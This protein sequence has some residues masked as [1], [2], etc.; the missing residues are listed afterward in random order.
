MIGLQQVPK[1]SEPSIYTGAFSYLKSSILGFLTAVFAFASGFL[2]NNAAFQQLQI[3]GKTTAG[4]SVAI[5]LFLIFLTLE[6]IFINRRSF[7]ASMLVAS[8]VALALG[9]FANFSQNLLLAL[10]AAAVIIVAGGMITRTAL[11]ESLK[12]SF[13]RVAN[14]S[15]KFGILALAV[16]AAVLFFNVF[17]TKP[18]EKNN[19][20]LSEGLMDTT[21]QI[22]SKPLASVFGGVDFSKTLRDS[23]T[24]MVDQQ[25]QQDPT[26][27]DKVTLAQRQQ[28]IDR[29]LHDLQSRLGGIFGGT[30]NVDEKLSSAL[31]DAFLNKINTLPSSARSVIMII[32]AVLVLFTVLAVSPIIRPIIAGLAFLFYEIL[33][34]SGFGSI[35]Y[36]TR[37][38]ETIVLP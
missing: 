37:S 25:I 35:I 10:A 30:L 5:V 24:E 1:E 28:I 7:L 36:E 3:D 27:K 23:A 33:L 29:S 4:L 16:V 11:D 12:I 38:K 32:G 21:L 19:P 22:L 6:V 34:A 9:F 2:I 8:S 20:I 14:N 17:S 31:Y 15:I 26:L 18:L 13:L